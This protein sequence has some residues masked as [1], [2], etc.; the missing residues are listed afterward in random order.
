MQE[1]DN[2]MTS[3]HPKLRVL[4]FILSLI[5]GLGGI[6]IFITGVVNYEIESKE[7][8]WA[9]AF[10]D[11]AI[12]AGTILAACAF[13]I[14]GGIALLLAVLSAPKAQRPASFM[15]WWWFTAAII[16]VG[17]II[18]AASNIVTNETYQLAIGWS[19]VGCMAISVLGG[20]ILGIRVFRLREHGAPNRIVL[21]LAASLLVAA[22]PVAAC[23]AGL[24]VWS[25]L[26]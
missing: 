24:A 6:A 14:F 21:G 10:A 17:V 20:F 9:G 7:S 2:H 22:V 3:H 11:L 15:R 4:S 5:G 1:Q 12:T 25:V 26:S 19:G 16:P 23:G 8:G 18:L 13:F